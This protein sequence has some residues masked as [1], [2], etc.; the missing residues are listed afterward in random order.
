[1]PPQGLFQ[2]QEGVGKWAPEAMASTVVKLSTLIFCFFVQHL[3]LTPTTVG[4][5][6]KAYN[7]FMMEIRK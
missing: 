7:N 6:Q 4:I 1:M 2:A 3:A 5:M